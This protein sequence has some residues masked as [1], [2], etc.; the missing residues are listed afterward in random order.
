M[1]RPPQG[2]EQSGRSA[3][4]VRMRHFKSWLLVIGLASLVAEAIAAA[5]V[6]WRAAANA[7]RS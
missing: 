7:E 5:A 1:L 4:D 3:D 6:F 2:L